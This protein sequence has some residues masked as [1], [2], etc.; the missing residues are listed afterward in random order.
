MMAAKTEVSRVIRDQAGRLTG[1]EKPVAHDD[2][3][4]ALLAL[5]FELES[6]AYANGYAAGVA[7]GAKASAAAAAATADQRQHADVETGFEA[8]S[9]AGV[10]AGIKAGATA[11]FNSGFVAGLETGL[12]TGL[13]AG[14]ERVAQWT[15]SGD[16]GPMPAPKITIEGDMSALRVTIE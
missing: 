16:D 11:G 12:R 8:G 1:I 13:I 7:S 14:V 3:P 2:A 15:E 5:G 10:D 9:K 4:D 6:A